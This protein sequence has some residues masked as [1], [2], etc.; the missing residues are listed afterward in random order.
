MT[1]Q[2]TSEK[3]QS[4]PI[5]DFPVWKTIKLGTIKTGE[6]L[7]SVLRKNG[8]DVSDCAEYT[9]RKS[10][11]FP[12]GLEEE[13]DLVK[14]SAKDLGFDNLV[15]YINGYPHYVSRG[16]VYEQAKKLGL[17]ICPLEVGPQLRLQYD[18][19]SE[20]ESVEV[21]TET[22]VEYSDQSFSL[23]MH[24]G[25]AWIHEYHEYLLCHYFKLE[26][27]QLIFI[28]PRK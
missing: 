5:I 25:K 16:E 10:G 19:Q 21:C 17:K 24:E 13:V 26:E 28:K 22:G 23:L 7:V 6:E 27:K 20:G 2:N 18:N 1:T 4:S 8:N 15:P 11:K 12:V 14:V 9:L 3:A